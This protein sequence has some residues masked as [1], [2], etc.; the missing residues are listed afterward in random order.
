[1]E[2]L[3]G[4]PRIVDLYGH[5]GSSVSERSKIALMYQG[6]LEGETNFGMLIGLYQVIVEA[7][8]FEVEEYIVPN[9]YI[10]QVDLQDADE[11]KPQNSY[12]AAE[13]LGMALEMAESLADLHGFPDGVM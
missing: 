12:N 11:V 13:K 10:K 6:L 4:S 1:M 2:R 8:P 7:I 3:S 5:C 9:G